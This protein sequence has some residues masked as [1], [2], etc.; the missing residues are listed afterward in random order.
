MLDFA[1]YGAETFLPTPLAIHEFIVS[2]RRALFFESSA[3][4]MDVTV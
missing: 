4:R 1:L 2:H 3:D